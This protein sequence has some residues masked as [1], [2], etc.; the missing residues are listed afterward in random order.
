MGISL[1]RASNRTRLPGLCLALTGLIVA[2]SG[3][4]CGGSG[5]KVSRQLFLA[6]FTQPSTATQ[7]RGIIQ[8]A[9]KNDFLRAIRPTALESEFEASQP[10]GT[11]LGRLSRP[12]PVSG[13]PMLTENLLV[14]EAQS[15]SLLSAS[16]TAINPATGRNV[17][18]LH[19]SQRG[20]DEAQ[21]EPATLSTVVPPLKLQNGWIMVFDSGSKNILA[22][23]EENPRKVVDD[24]DGDGTATERTVVFRSPVL[25]NGQV[26]PDSRN[27]GQGNGLLASV[28]ISGTDTV[29]Q[30]KVPTEPVISNMVEIEKNKVL[31]FFT[32][33][34]IRAIHL[35][36]LSE[37]TIQADFDLDEPVRPSERLDVK[38]L[39]GRYKL[40]PEALITYRKIAEQ[41]TGNDNL[42]LDKAPPAV[43]THPKL[44]VPFVLMFDRT[45]STFIRARLLKD[46]A[47]AVVGAEIA[48]A[49]SSA[50]FQASLQGAAGAST[51]DP[52]YALQGGFQRSD[53]KNRQIMYFETK[54][55]NLVAIDPDPALNPDQNLKVF[56][57]TS[58]FLFRRNPRAP[59]EVAQ[60]NPES[61]IFATR[62]VRL[63]RLAFDVELGQLISISYSSGV[64]VVVASAAE[65]SVVTNDPLSN[66]T[67][68]EPLDDNNLRAFDS[69]TMS[70]LE[71]QLGYSAFPV[72]S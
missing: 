13:E 52:P 37:E 6:P 58:G 27:F 54:S 33:G 3:F 40:F 41:I 14:Y 9:K 72:K 65:L 8:R 28:V 64:V 7:T 53:G 62:D 59:G 46:A 24:L 67:Y 61:L 12:D 39:R 70:L 11:V 48:E 36:E 18:R 25:P 71:V 32:F 19:Y 2:G 10:E 31:I 49:V 22:F 50:S 57:S 66:L 44:P 42:E 15:R 63:N 21:G 30:L 56:T 26:N 17:V 35:L 16:M 69:R 38:L 20:L 34:T 55:A 45:T 29:D 43:Y 60:G 5:K 1:R 23:R 68:L 4:G 47:D 51:V